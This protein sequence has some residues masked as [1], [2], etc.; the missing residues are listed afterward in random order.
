MGDAEIQ[1]IPAQMGQGILLVGAV[2]S[3]NSNLF[4]HWSLGLRP[5]AGR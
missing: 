4:Y 2:A 3:S 5:T 1:A